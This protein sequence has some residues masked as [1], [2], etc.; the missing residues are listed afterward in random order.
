MV[1]LDRAFQITVPAVPVFAIVA[2][3]VD[4]VEYSA[5][6]N[7]R[8][9]M[10]TL[11]D[12]VTLIVVPDVARLLLFAWP[13]VGTATDVVALNATTTVAELSPAPCVNVA[14]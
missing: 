12:G 2:V 7:I 8:L 11:P 6:T 1:N 13:N 5:P 10:V 3:S 9:L 14:A 4:P